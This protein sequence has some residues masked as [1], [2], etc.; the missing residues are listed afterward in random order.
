MI[1]KNEVKMVLNAYIRSKALTDKCYT[2]VQAKRKI[3]RADKKIVENQIFFTKHPN[4]N[5]W[6]TRF[7]SPS[8]TRKPKQV[9]I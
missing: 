9:F 2:N 4:F 6:T 5:K 7:W 8:K 3:I 1:S